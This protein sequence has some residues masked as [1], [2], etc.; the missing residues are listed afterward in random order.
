[1]NK[2]MLSINLDRTTIYAGKIDLEKFEAGNYVIVNRNMN[3]VKDGLK[4][5]DKI[6]IKKD[7]VDLE[8]KA[9]AVVLNKDSNYMSNTL[10]LLS[11]S[12]KNFKNGIL[13]G[14]SLGTLVF[15]AIAVKNMVNIALNFSAIFFI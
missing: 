1:M 12:N 7:G 8:L 14:V 9:M 2:D 15:L 4:A 10:W 5:G 3:E 11:I 6:T 13:I